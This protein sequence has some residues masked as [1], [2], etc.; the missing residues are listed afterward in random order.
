M[1]LNPGCP[2]TPGHDHSRPSEDVRL[3]DTKHGEDEHGPEDCIEGPVRSDTSAQDEGAGGISRRAFLL[4][5]A[6][7]VAGL[8]VV[9]YSGVTV[10][11]DDL[12]PHLDPT[13]GTGSLA[14]S[15]PETLVA[16]SHVLVIPDYRVNDDRIRA[17]VDE[18]TNEVPGLLHE[19][20]RGARVLDDLADRRF[21]APFA[22]ISIEA[23]DQVLDSVFWRYPAEYR[24][25]ME[26]LR[27]KVLRRIERIRNGAELRRVRQLVMRDLLRRIYRAGIALVIGYSNL[28]G[29]PGNPRDY[30]TAPEGRPDEAPSMSDLRA[31]RAE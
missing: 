29:V 6:V 17:V 15:E 27:P 13:T 30:V 2:D 21:F 26:D 14:A 9:G 24:G 12:R 16:L 28:P 11:R 31:G 22:A 20:R 18:A 19:Y 8:G 7:G 25:G 23:R 5:S 4:G 3:V 1:D 10:A